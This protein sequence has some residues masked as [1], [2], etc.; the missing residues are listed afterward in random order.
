MKENSVGRAFWRRNFCCSHSSSDTFILSTDYYPSNEEKKTENPPSFW[1]P[2]E[3]SPTNEEKV[4][5]QNLKGWRLIVVVIFAWRSV[6]R[7]V[8]CPVWFELSHWMSLIQ[9][10][11]K[12]PT[13]NSSFFWGSP[14]GGGPQ[15]NNEFM[16]GF[17]WQRL[18]VYDMIP[19]FRH[20]TKRSWK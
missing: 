4:Y 3:F 11:Q 17:F 10:F 19:I 5:C 6:Y 9:S 13:I 1:A 20:F 18:L 15:I 2:S 7:I 12:K 14:G 8:G 16:V